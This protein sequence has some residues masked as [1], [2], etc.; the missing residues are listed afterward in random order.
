VT[1]WL[2]DYAT[3]QGALTVADF[4]RA[5]VDIV[6]WKVSHGL[7]TYAARPRIAAEI[8]DARAR[9]LGVGTFH[10]LIGNH[11]G[12]DQARH[13]YARMVEVGAHLN[14]AHTVD[15]EEQPDA[16][17]ELPPTLRH[18]V[19]YVT[20][21]HR[22]LRRP[23][24]LYTGDWWWTTPGRNWQAAALTPY[25]MA[26]PNR[27]YPGR[28]PGDTAPEW[29]VVDV[30]HPNGYGGWRTLSCMQYA[31]APLTYPDGT[32]GTTDVSHAAIR[33]R[34]VWAGLTGGDALMARPD[35][36]NAPPQ[37]WAVP[38]T[39]AEIAEVRTRLEAEAGARARM[40][41]DSLTLP[42]H[43]LPVL[44]A[45]PARAGEVCAPTIAAELA[46][47][48]TLGGGNSGCVGNLAHT[49]GFHRGA[50][51]VPRTDYSRANDPAGPDGAVDGS[52]CCA[53]DFAHAGNP[54]LRAMHAGLLARLMADDPELRMICEF[55]GQPW[56]DKS[57][58]YWARWNGVGVI[59]LYTGAGH[60][61][62][63]HISKYRSRANQPA[64][65]WTGDTVSVADVINAL[66][67]PEGRAAVYAAVNQDKI[68]RWDPKTSN[69]VPPDPADPTAH[70]MTWQ[71]ALEYLGRDLGI[72]VPLLRQVLAALTQFAG[73]DFVDEA[74][75]IQGVLAGTNL[76]VQ[77]IADAVLAGMSQ[78]Q[79]EQFVNALV[80]RVRRGT[81]DT[82]A[83]GFVG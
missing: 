65:L 2:A 46:E 60:D 17:D 55:I 24:M 48:T 39:D 76:G 74:A 30:D 19:D 73:R 77:A 8:A 58:Y 63:S 83:S 27:G 37:A 3:Y 6:N 33:D 54:R 49:Y 44:P 12:A 51:F 25:L 29:S 42:A 56:P 81:G 67:S 28:Y 38:M 52:W 41:L 14:A 69:W 78:A 40:M 21:M 59:Q 15:V 1:L 18:V 57:V 20:T 23:V 7:G 36:G 80:E 66:K 11:S 82:P 70:T 68:K 32:R 50:A 22:L 43:L 34:T 79:A 16:D 53:G 26:A 75:I 13:A 9:G 61:T 31:V 62:W 45:E 35:P 4:D 47:W 71:S 64:K 10:W 5:G 72:A